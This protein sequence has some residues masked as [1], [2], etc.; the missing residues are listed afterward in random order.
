M[1]SN[2]SRQDPAGS[3]SRLPAGGVADLK[4]NPVGGGSSSVHTRVGGASETESLT[5]A[6]TAAEAVSDK[7]HRIKPIPPKVRI[8]QI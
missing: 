7:L 6:A 5:I 3:I 1:S 2:R 4:G 8:A